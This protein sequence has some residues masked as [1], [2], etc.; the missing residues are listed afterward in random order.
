M[1]DH[2]K[3]ETGNG[4]EIQYLG[5][6]LELFAGANIW[7]AY[8]LA[9]IAP[10]IG[11]RV[12]EVGA[13]LGTVMRNL[14]P[15][16]VKHWLAL[17]PDPI[18]ADRLISS[19]HSGA[20]PAFCEPCLGTTTDLAPQRQFDTVLYIDVLEHIEDDRAE[21][22]RAAELVAPQGALV[23]LG[24][25]HQFL[26]SS[27]DAAIGHFRRYE[28]PALLALSPPGLTIARARYLDSVGLLASL[29]NRLL[30]KQSAPTAAQIRLWD[31]VMVRASRCVDPLLGFTIGKSVF[32]VWRRL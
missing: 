19:K 11:E 22:A 17:E 1:S 28:R 9:Q 21:L 6:E 13:G 8:W 26:Y 27:F 7:R 5:N 30:L 14:P 29:G 24:P 3:A 23:V 4:T 10:F 31:R 20:L 2:R 15:L 25:A 32:A 16:P 12:L 18:M